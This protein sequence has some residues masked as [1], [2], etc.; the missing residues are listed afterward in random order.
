MNEN[1]I[2]NRQYGQWLSTF[3]WDLFSTITYK[4]II[5]R[6]RNRQIMSSI[7]NSLNK[8]EIKHNIFW[9]MEYTS[10]G[11]QTHNHMLIEG[12]GV[13]EE[14]DRYLKDKNLVDDRFVKHISYNSSLGANYYVTKYISSDD[15]EYDF[16]LSK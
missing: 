9:I 12:E 11:H 6:R 14:I 3:K 8:L 15:I 1:R 5:K 10:H 16:S 7:V 4:H 13:K 2:I